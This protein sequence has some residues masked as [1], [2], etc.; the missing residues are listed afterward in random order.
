MVLTENW[1]YSWA[2]KTQTVL[3]DIGGGTDGSPET[4]VSA[5][6]PMPV[7]QLTLAWGASS[8]LESSHIIS[9]AAITLARLDVVI[10]ATTGWL[11]LFDAAT[12]PADGAVTPAYYIPIISNGTLGGV[13]LEWNRPLS[14]ATGLVAVFSSTGPFTKTASATAAFMW[15]VK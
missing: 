15:Q 14:F 6:I 11:M 7:L 2:D 9:A 3:L 1:A 4:V 12:A 10:G 13:T 8:A 5:A